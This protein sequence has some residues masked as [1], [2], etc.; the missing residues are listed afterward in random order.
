MLVAADSHAMA[1][2]TGSWRQLSLSGIPEHLAARS[3]HCLAV[4]NGKVYIFGGELQPRTPIGNELLIVDLHDGKT[5]V[6]DGSD[7]ATWPSSRVG[8]SIVSHKSTNALYSWG[9]RGGKEM[10]PIEVKTKSEEKDRDDVW[11][12]D[13]STEIWSKLDTQAKEDSAYPEARSYHAMTASGDALY[14]HAGCPSN[15]EHV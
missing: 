3:S 15:G 2:P 8:A 1:A 11:K 4:L 5:R 12:F 7:A 9:G 10:K 14:I 6:L 13:I